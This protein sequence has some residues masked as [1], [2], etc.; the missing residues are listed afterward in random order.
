MQQDTV[1]D[2]QQIQTIIQNEVQKALASGPAP[3]PS[4]ADTLAN[5]D[6]RDSEAA[7]AMLDWLLQTNRL[8]RVG[9]LDG[10][11]GYLFMYQ[12][13]QG[14]TKQGYIPGATQG[15]RIVDQAVEAQRASGKA[16]A[17]RGMC[18]HCLSVVRDD[19]GQVVLDD[20]TAN[21]VCPSSPDGHHAF[22]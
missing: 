22:A 7:L 10:G 17:K 21:A 6:P 9:V 12:E 3:A 11:A 13:P 19:Q 20:D 4:F 14:S 8:G 1:V 15:D 16:P 5:V 18:P 2:A